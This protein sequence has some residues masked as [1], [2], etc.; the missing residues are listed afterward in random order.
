MVVLFLA[1]AGHAILATY[2]YAEA[3]R[4]AG[5]LLTD[6]RELERAAVLIYY[7]GDL[8][9]LLL[10]VALFASS[11]A[12][13]GRRLPRD[14]ANE[15]AVGQPSMPARPGARGAG[16]AGIDDDRFGEAAQGR[17]VEG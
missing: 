13:R 10:A 15:R 2:L 16:A 7:G 5:P 3:D 14:R 12:R 6:A 8:A 11:Y 9:E 1:A 4:M 17:W